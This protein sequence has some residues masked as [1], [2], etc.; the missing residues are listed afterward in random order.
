MIAE[1]IPWLVALLVIVLMGWALMRDNKSKKERTVEE[2][3]RDVA[4]REN[5]GSAM[6]AASGL[7]LQKF[8]GSQNEA[9]IEYKQD[10]QRGTTRTG[11]KGDDAD[12]TANSH[13]EE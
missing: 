8:T 10:E 4:S 7:T 11:S 12:R 1:L 6:M 5:F 2:F 9:A 13:G 3:E